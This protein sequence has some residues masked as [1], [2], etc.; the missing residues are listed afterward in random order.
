[1]PNLVG[2]KKIE[3]DFSQWYPGEEQEARGTN[4]EYKKFNLNIRKKEKKNFFFFFYLKDDSEL[5]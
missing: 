1:M 4:L 5:K 3:P 2:V